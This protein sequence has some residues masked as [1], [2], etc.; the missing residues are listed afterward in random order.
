M[1]WVLITMPKS[2]IFWTANFPRP[3]DYGGYFIMMG[4]FGLFVGPGNLGVG[5][6]T[7]ART[8]L[9]GF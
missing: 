8:L 4:S 3:C 6:Y 5:T 9:H 7:C 1:L 2:V